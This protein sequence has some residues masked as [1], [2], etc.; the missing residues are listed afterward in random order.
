[1]NITTKFDIGDTVYKLCQTSY[2]EITFEKLVVIRFWVGK[3][4]IKY[5]CSTSGSP[6]EFCKK[7]F[8]SES[9]LL[10]FEET[11]QAKLDWYRERIK[12]VEGVLAE[13]KELQERIANVL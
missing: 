11:H 5:Q 13:L 4:G 12:Y 2:K 10:T 1:M 7:E 6:D 9:E 8:L 3:N